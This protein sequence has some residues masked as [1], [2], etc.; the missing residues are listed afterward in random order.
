MFDIIFFSGQSNMQGQTESPMP[1]EPVEQGLEY[2]YLTDSLVPLCHPVGED[3]GEL[4]LAAHQGNGSLIPDFCRAYI[5]ETSRP[6][7]AVSVAK[8]ATTVSQWLAPGER[9]EMLIRKCRGAIRAV[10]REN[11]GKMWFVWLQGESDAIE[12]TPKETYEEQLRFFKKSLDEALGID[13]FSLIRVGKFTDTP[14]DIEIIRGQESLGKTQEFVL[15]TRVTGDC[16]KDPQQWMNPQAKGHY[17]NRAMTR[18]GSIAGKN[19]ALYGKNIP[20]ALEPEPYP[21]VEA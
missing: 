10:G 2:R 8:G 3:V 20:F 18:I 4:L 16:T 11:V 5:Q 12:Q 17:N 9:F 13:G 15:L 21:E 7:V 1:S 14:W 19:L 6:V